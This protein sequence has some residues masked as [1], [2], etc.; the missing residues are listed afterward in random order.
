MNQTAPIF[1]GAPD[2]GAGTQRRARRGFTIM[3]LCIVLFIM[4]LLMGALLPSMLTAL[5]EQAVRGDA[6]QLAL[7]VK[8]AMCQSSEQHRA[9]VIDFTSASMSLH[10]A[11]QTDDA[12]GPTSFTDPAAAPN[13]GGD[14][15]EMR[16]ELSAPN[17]LLVPDPEKAHA[18]TE[19]KTSTWLFQPGELC[20]A[21][22]VRFT[23]GDAW[24]ELNFN[25][26]TGDVENESSYFP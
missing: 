26:L 21:Q 16:G 24:L 2:N 20:P 10:P 8:T 17:R 6:H 4:A 25:A 14:D 23:H 5:T 18:W 3:E 1:P 13:A 19:V 11:A 7:M 9:Y 12:A 22:T 15:V